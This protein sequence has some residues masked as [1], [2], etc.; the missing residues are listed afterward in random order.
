MVDQ[1]ISLRW[2]H[3]R[4]LRMAEKLTAGEARDVSPFD[5]G[6]ETYLLPD[7]W[8]EEDTD[9]CDAAREAWIWSIGRS[10]KSG[11]VLATTSGFL[12]QNPD[13][14]CLFLR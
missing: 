13:Y 7:G 6:D 11:K 12:Y 5:Q 3:L 4:N 2:S 9:Y 8:F 10:L 14:E 1:T